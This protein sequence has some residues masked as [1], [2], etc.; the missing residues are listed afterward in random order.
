ML[1]LDQGC[2][3]FRDQKLRTVVMGLVGKTP[4]E[5]QNDKRGQLLRVDGASQVLPGAYWAGTC[6][7]SSNL[8]PFTCCHFT[9][10]TVNA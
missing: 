1:A 6:P 2:R 7:G 4:A 3:I 9:I 8:H 5:R 10:L